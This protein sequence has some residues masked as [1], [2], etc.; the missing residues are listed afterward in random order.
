ML[1]VRCLVLK[2]GLIVNLWK[3]GVSGVKWRLN[4]MYIEN[5]YNLSI[6]WGVSGVIV[7]LSII[8]FEGLYFLKGNVKPSVFH[9]NNATKFI[10]WS[11]GTNNDN[12]I[13]GKVCIY[14][15]F[16]NFS[17]F[18]CENLA[19]KWWAVSILFTIYVYSEMA[20]AGLKDEKSDIKV[21]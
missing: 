7:S 6:F 1:N 12:M 19:Y 18:V 4:D 5:Y 8:T 9:R 21:S 20:Y 11:L 14:Q 13:F 15:C 17:L 10:T 2:W 3:N 16:K